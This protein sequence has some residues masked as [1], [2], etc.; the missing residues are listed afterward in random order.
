[1][2]DPPYRQLFIGIVA[3]VVGVLGLL[4]Y[5]GAPKKH[6]WK[7]IVPSPMHWTGIFLGGGLVL[8]FVYV[9]L[10]VGSSRADAGS[11]MNILSGLIVAF[12]IGVVI[13]AWSI[14]HVR[15]L[16]FEWR[17]DRIFYR[18]P[19][20]T[21]VSHTFDDISGVRRTA[22]GWIIVSFVQGDA[23]KLDEHASGTPEFLVSVADRR[24]DLLP[25]DA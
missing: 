10:F 9:R 1:M 22:V 8:L 14:I 6:G 21:A 13:C 4:G 12:T 17:G 23:I 3:I 25:E 18:G 11:Q 15:R 16:V 5:R 7:R 2:F 20:R 19:R 24:T